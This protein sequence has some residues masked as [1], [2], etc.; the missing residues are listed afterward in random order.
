MNG[1]MIKIGLAA[2]VV[3]VVASLA[4]EGGSG[5][6][7][8][9]EQDK[10]GSVP[11][12]WQVAETGG[13]GKLAA[14]AVVADES[15]SDSAHAVVITTNT[16]YGGTFNLLIAKETKYKD[17][18]IEVMVKAIA[19]KED[20]GGGPIWRAKDADNYY[21]CRWNPLENNI[22]LYYVKDGR[23]KQLASADITTDPTVW[24]EIEVKHKGSKIEV[25]F[26]GKDVIEFED[27]TFT[28]AGMVGLWVKADG[29][30]AFDNFEVSVADKDKD[31][32]HDEEKDSDDD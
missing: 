20:Q 11:K 19:G 17:L 1:S 6:E 10:V 13:E 29:R 25:E 26:D 5:K 12:G 8:T 4:D 32:A 9:F 23:R 27:S 7:W 31:E 30:S 15:A 24:H 2:M 18:E 28:E 22:R 14:W 21:V 3:S 16:N